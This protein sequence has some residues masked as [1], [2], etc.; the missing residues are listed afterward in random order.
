MANLRQADEQRN[1]MFSPSNAMFVCNKWKMVEKHKQ[2]NTFKELL[3]RLISSWGDIEKIS[4]YYIQRTPK[5]IRL[6]RTGN[7]Q[8]K[9]NKINMQ[10]TIHVFQRGRIIYRLCPHI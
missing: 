9:L 6:I 7:K 10:T 2:S 4:A 3:E 5:G 8:E 1:G